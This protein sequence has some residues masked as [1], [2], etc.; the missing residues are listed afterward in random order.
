M[1]K[2]NRLTHK[3]LSKHLA[4]DEFDEMFRKANHSVQAPYGRVT[5]HVFWE[6]NYDFL[7]TYCYNGA[8]NRFIKSNDI[9]FTQPVQRDKAK[10]EAPHFLWGTKTLN[11][12]NGFIYDQYKHFIGPVHFKSIAKLL[13][14]Q[15]I[16]VVLDELL[17]VVKTLVQGNILEL[18][19]ILIATLKPDLKLPAYSSTSFGILGKVL[20]NVVNVVQYPKART[21]LFHHLR[22]LGNAIVFCLMIEQALSQEEVDQPPM[23]NLSFISKTFFRFKTCCTLPRSKKLSNVQFSRRAKSLK[24]SRSDLSR[25]MLRCKLSPTSRAWAPRSRQRL[26]GRPTFSPSKI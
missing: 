18:T 15:G 3:L 24:R 9:A 16:A 17:S 14:Y 11:Q 6:L 5:L 20:N 2:V 1:I 25:D 23:T 7:P 19:K 10:T 12:A 26:H 13:G 21:D 4:L 22:E 8:T